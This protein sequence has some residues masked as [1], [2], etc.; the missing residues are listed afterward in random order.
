MAQL[1]AHRSRL[2]PI[3]FAKIR[4]K[5]TYHF[6]L[7]ICFPLL[8]HAFFLRARS[9]SLSTCLSFESHPRDEWEDRRERKNN[10]YLLR[11]LLFYVFHLVCNF[12][13]CVRVCIYVRLSN[14][15]SA[16]LPI[17]I[18]ASNFIRSHELPSSTAGTGTKTKQINTRTSEWMA[19]N[20]RKK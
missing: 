6:K 8:R 15:H 3:D 18:C 4:N 2:F 12:G 17:S 14:V 9:L 7:D 16:G 10:I 11:L 13:E 19:K 1:G 20:E 5:T